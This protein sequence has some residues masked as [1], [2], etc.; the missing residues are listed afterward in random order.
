MQPGGYQIVTGSSPYARDD[1][2]LVHAGIGGALCEGDEA[3]HI[4]STSTASKA[5]FNWTP[6]LPQPTFDR[7]SPSIPF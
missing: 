2:P 1:V 7:V 4:S 6:F 5:N 3:T